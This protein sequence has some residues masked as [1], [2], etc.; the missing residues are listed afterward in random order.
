M[1]KLT[2]KNFFPEYLINSKTYLLVV[3]NKDKKILLFNETFTKKINFL[4]FENTLPDFENTLVTDEVQK[5]R[6]NIQLLFQEN[7]SNS[8]E[9]EL[10]HRSS[11]KIFLKIHWNFSLSENQEG[12]SYLMGMGH[13]ISD[14]EANEKNKMYESFLNMMPHFLYR[15]DLQGKITYA[16]KTVL[17]SLGLSI[18]SILGKTAYDFY[19]FELAQKY[20]NDNQKVISSGKTITLVEEHIIPTTQEKKY[21]EVMKMPIVEDG[22]VC[23][24]QGVFVDIT[25]KKKQEEKIHL[26]SL[27][28]K[29]TTNI[30]I[31]TDKDRKITWVNESFTKVTGYT[32][33]EVIGKNP[34]CFLQFEKTNQETVRQVR[35]KLNAKES[36]RFEIL[37]I[38]K[39]KNEYWLDVEIEPLF[40]D[41]GELIGFMALQT[42]ITEQKKISQS[43][44]L[45]NTAINNIHEAVFLIDEEGNFFYTN[46]ES[47]K[48]LG[49]DWKEFLQ[50]NVFQIDT[51]FDKSK[52]GE[53][54]EQL[55]TSKTLTFQTTHLTKDGKVFPVEVS[56]NYIEYEGKGYNLALVR[57]VSEKKK[58]EE[59]VQ[60]I[61]NQLTSTLANTPNVAIQWYD[62]EGKV[63][64]W[65][66]ASEALYGIKSEDAIGKTLDQLI[67]TPE[68]AA[69][70]LNVLKTIKL[71]KKPFGPYESMVRRYDGK[72]G[73]VLATT[74]MIPTN[75]NQSCFVCM[76]VDITERKQAEILLKASEEKFRSLINNLQVGVLLQGAKTEIL[77]WNHKALELLGLTEE[78]I[79]GKTSFDPYWKVIHEDGT[80]FPSEK[81]PVTEAI[82]TKK[83]VFGVVMGVN[84][85]SKKDI[86][87]LLVDAL[88]QLDEY[89][90]VNQV[91]CTFT[92]ITKIK[93]AE[94]IILNQNNILKEIAWQQSHEVRRP[95]ANI[96]GL[97]NIINIDIEQHKA[98][99]PQYIEYLKVA[100][101]ELDKIIKHIVQ[102]SFE[103]YK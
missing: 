36:C 16:N 89:G 101:E 19:P 66:P 91:V 64:Y 1:T 32:L 4:T 92:D 21:V 6:K 96:L 44:A 57:D 75:N 59:V 94:S 58:A 52:W 31:I 20:E 10:V 40:G 79:S 65:N 38:G 87:W 78:Q 39:Y 62:E 41:D 100:T 81:H 80:D 56:A 74:F 82:N 102:K 7:Q 83:P 53:H 27:I 11:E 55:K 18:E 71:E 12:Q 90:N 70:F 68:E 2:L 72:M 3:V 60:L 45:L 50:M 76:D 28:A 33:E 99:N 93:N 35:A 86:V 34:S 54:W 15:V 24:I 8:S 95:V 30:V 46:Q 88:P 29:K 97:I 48:K 47:S 37:N 13:F 84:R 51:N 103:I 49:Y 9:F 98:Y 42:D 61:Q 43:I 22:K 26:L 23:G 5:F 73:W 63:L 14:N 85:P 77:L 67:H 69:A 17:D 25:E